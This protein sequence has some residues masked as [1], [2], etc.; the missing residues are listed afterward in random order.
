M[1]KNINI[2]INN[3]IMII[4]FKG[5][6]K[7]M[8]SMLDCISNK[9]EGIIKSRLGHNFPSNII[10][11]D[12]ILSKYKSKCSYVIGIYNS[13]SIAHELLH[14]KYY[15]D[16]KYRT[17]IIAEWNDLPEKT[18]SHITIFLKKLGYGDNVIID[19]YQAYRYTESPNFFG[20]K[21]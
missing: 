19:E 7:L 13:Q 16:E 2:H 20:I 1:N 14:A 5:N 4:N 18:R 15:M 10:P 12:H 11:S 3:M 21:L 17:K 6:N 8:N 9:Y